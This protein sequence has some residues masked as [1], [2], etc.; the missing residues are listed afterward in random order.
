MAY[1]DFESLT[2]GTAS[3][4]MLRDKPFNIAKNPKSDKY[5]RGLFSIVYT[6]FDKKASGSGIKNENISNKEIF[7]K[8]LHK[9]IIRKY[10]KRKVRL[11][12]IGNIS[13][14]DLQLQF[15]IKFNEGIRFFY[16]ICV[17]AHRLFLS[18]KK[19]VL[20]LLMLFKNF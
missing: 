17:N 10:D 11:S 9:P 6:F 20:Q 5:Q 16:V 15:I 2:S 18:K 3:D 19:K 13:G 12:F 1:K 8:E 4:K 7:T 14:A